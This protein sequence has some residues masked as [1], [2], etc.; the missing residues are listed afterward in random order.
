MTLRF[1][2]SCSPVPLSADQVLGGFELG[3]SLMTDA[4]Q[5]PVQSLPMPVLQDESVNMHET[6][7][8]DTPVESGLTEG[9][10]WRRT[11]GLLFGVIS[12]SEQT[13]DPLSAV[14]PLRQVSERAYQRIFRLLDQQG[15]PH[16]WRVWNYIPDI[17]GEQAG[18]ERYRQFNMGRGDAFERGARSVTEQVPAA[19]AL[20]VVAGGSLSI[21]FLCGASPLV[22]VENPRQVSAYLYPR[23]YGPRSP[24]FSRAGLA[25]LGSQELIF[26]SGTASIVGH[27][28]LHPNDVVAQTRESLDNVAAVLD[29]VAGRSRLGR[30]DLSALEYRAY[31][32]HPFE[33]A[34][35]QREMVKRVGQAP[36]LYVQA[37]V[38]RQELLVEIEA[39]GLRDI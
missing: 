21:A 28:S 24:T 17:H 20:G 13:A 36:V 37:D 22:P 8:V 39:F 7:L 23:I 35:V 38:C 18:L 30:M 6:W 11:E 3:A 34:A 32:R 10:A 5:W 29:E 31:V 2:S 27:E 12:L 14:P 9:I 26:V 16:L 19:C 1:L 4:R 15:L 33:V 25:Y